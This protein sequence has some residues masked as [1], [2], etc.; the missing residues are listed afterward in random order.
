[1]H[2]LKD[3][4]LL[5]FKFLISHATIQS[6]IHKIFGD[7]R[8]QFRKEMCYEVGS[9]TVPVNCHTLFELS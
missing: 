3:K 7:K 6:K 1:M 2:K 4:K 5:S 8:L 9:M